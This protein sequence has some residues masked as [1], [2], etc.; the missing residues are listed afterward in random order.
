LCEF[1]KK[2]YLQIPTA[3]LAE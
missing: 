3:L 1:K 2:N